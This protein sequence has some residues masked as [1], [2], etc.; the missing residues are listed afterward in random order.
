MCGLDAA[1]ICINTIKRLL[2]EN[3]NEFSFISISTI[4]DSSQNLLPDR[5]EYQLVFFVRD[6]FE[7]L[8]SDEIRDTVEELLTSEYDILR[9]VAI[10]TINH[11]YKELNDLFWGGDGNPLNDYRSK[12]ELFELLKIIALLLLKNK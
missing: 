6:M 4:E 9:R 11:H 8:K 1:K 3:E 7:N 5:Y 12:H 10:H 2:K